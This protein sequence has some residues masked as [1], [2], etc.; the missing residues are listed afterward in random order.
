MG[1]STAGDG[2][3]PIDSQALA[4][5]MLENQGGAPTPPVVDNNIEEE[6]EGESGDESGNE[7]QKL[8]GHPAW[9][10]I[11]SEI[12]AEYH[13][14]VAPKLKEWDSGVTRRFQE[15]HSQYEPLKTFE[16]LLEQD[17]DADN[18]SR[19]IGLYQALNTDPRQVYEALGEAYG[20][21]N[22]QESTDDEDDYSEFRLPPE[23]QQQLNQQQ[24]MLEQMAEYI[25]SQQTTMQSQEESAALD[26]YLEQLAS[27]YGEFDEDY[28]LTKMAAGI[29]GEV[30]V[31]TYFE[32]F[33]VGNPSGN[34]GP[35][36]QPPKVIGS[37]GAGSGGVPSPR[38]QVT[39]LNSQETKDL[40][41]AMLQQT[42]EQQNS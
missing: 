36:K 13:E 24:L 38:P 14:V 12:P 3:Q 41:V 16:P 19:A 32:K 8:G 27:Q 11:L 17:I 7:G 26:E 25:Q 9:Q 6:N 42:A 29:D 30:A 39:N 21:V 4:L 20:F 5:Q 1:N 28:V 10:E 40:V 34:N 18:L 22:E 23:V 37:S 2:V 33:P 15:I 35:Q 31:R